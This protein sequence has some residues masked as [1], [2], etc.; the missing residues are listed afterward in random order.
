[1]LKLKKSFY[2]EKHHRLPLDQYIGNIRAGFTLCIKNNEHIFNE[3]KLVNQFLQYLIESL[4][5]YNCQ[6]W[7][8][9]FMPD[10][11]HLILEGKTDD[12]NLWKAM[13]LF[14]QKTGYWFSKNMN[15]ITW[16]KDFYDHILRTEEDLKKHIFYL[17]N[18][19]V[20]KG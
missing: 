3:M 15:N 12:S 20:R 11:V 1:M 5:K 9:V 6:N 18:N 7:I 4:S 19:P 17:L 16:Q 14:K 13:V 10:H 2:K 8:Y